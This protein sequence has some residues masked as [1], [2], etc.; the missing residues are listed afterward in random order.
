MD[1]GRTAHSDLERALRALS[2]REIDGHAARAEC[3]AALGQALWAPL[4]HLSASAGRLLAEELEP[5]VRREAE[6]VAAAAES[7]HELLAAHL[8]LASGPESAG[9]QRALFDL[10]EVLAPLLKAFAPRARR[11]EIGFAVR[12]GAD[13]PAV[14]IG[15]PQ[16]LRAIVR[17]LL[18]E[19]LR[20]ADCEEI[21]LGLSLA[22]GEGGERALEIALHGLGDDPARARGLAVCARLA[23]QLDGRMWLDMPSGGRG[24]VRLRMRCERVPERRRRARGALDLQHVTLVASPGIARDALVHNLAAQGV[25]C[26]VFDALRA[27]RAPRQDEAPRKTLI[28]DAL[29]EA[30]AAARLDGFLDALDLGSTFLISARPARVVLE[31]ERR[32]GV[33]G[34]LREPVLPRECLEVLAR[35]AHGPHPLDESRRAPA[36]VERLTILL[37]EAD[38]AQR[39]VARGLLERAGHTVVSVEDGLALTA[40]SQDRPFDA[41]LVDLDLPVLDAAACARLVRARELRLGRHTPIV[42]LTPDPARAGERDLA[43]SGLDACLGVPLDAE[44]LS[45]TLSRL[46][47]ARDFESG[48]A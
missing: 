22:P 19:A 14:L 31:S 25:A 3:A 4:A 18:D 46:C 35:S 27:V 5:A 15:E 10:Q 13:V 23:R 44:A 2:E 21:T 29:W 36:P 41:L 32:C 48:A 11:R 39:A 9:L 7:L 30:D 6:L 1:D 17:L 12:I 24:S 45:W 40:L 20:G 42:G 26:E 47:G 33:A 16:T 38:E 37:A 34:V 43:E 8:T 28:E